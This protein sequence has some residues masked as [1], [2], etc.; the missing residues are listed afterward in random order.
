MK[1]VLSKNSKRF[2]FYANMFLFS[3]INY[4][5]IL[6]LKDYKKTDLKIHI[7]YF[8]K[9]INKLE[10]TWKGNNLIISGKYIL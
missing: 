7:E 3:N 1:V 4:Y 6:I 5:I 8:E 2:I 9:F 10:K